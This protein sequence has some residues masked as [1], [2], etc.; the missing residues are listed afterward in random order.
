MEN[1][2]ALVMLKKPVQTHAGQFAKLANGALKDGDSVSVCGW[3]AT[4][5]FSPFGYPSR[6]Q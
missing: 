1:D 4:L 2:V 6:M 5:A 3:G